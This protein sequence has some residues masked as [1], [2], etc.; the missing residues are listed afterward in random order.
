MK[1][2]DFIFDCITIL[3]YKCHNVSLKHGWS[4]I[5]FSDWTKTKQ[6]TATNP[7]NDNDKCFQYAATSVLSQKKK[8]YVIK[9][10]YILLMFQ[11]INQ[12]VK[13]NRSSNDFNWNYLIIKKLPALIRRITSANN[14][15]YFCPN[16]LF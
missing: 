9:R 8:N 15:D 12:I 7:I 14:G 4:C 6:N 3:Y 11:N 5:N 13:K 1:G 10:I 16:C 2:S